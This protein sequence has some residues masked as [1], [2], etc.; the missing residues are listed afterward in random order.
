[1]R[2]FWQKII[3]VLKKLACDRLTEDVDFGK[4]KIIFSSDLGGYIKKRNCR[5]CGTENPHAYIEKPTHLKRVTVW[6]GFWSR[7]IIGTFFFGNE[8]EEAVTVNGDR[9]RPMLNECLFT[10]I[11]EEDFGNIW[12]QQDGSTCHTAEAILDV[13]RAVFVDRIISRRA[14]GVWP[15]RSWDLTPVDYYLWGAVKDK[16]YADKLETIDCWMNFCS[17]KLK[18]R[19]F[20][21]FGFNRTAL[22]ATQPKLYLM[23]CAQFLK[24]GLSAAKLMAFGHLGVEIW[25]RWTI[26]CEVPSKTSVTPTSSRDNWRFKGQYSW[27][28][29]WNTAAYNW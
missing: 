14:N 15:P 24:I 17:Q 10:K 29:W 5:I 20:A 4:K 12:F 1:M 11:E 7:C 28:Y 26:I 18:R 9:Y 22:R 13:L 6:C 19:L 16:R 23:F 3:V 25:H 8:Q 2:W 21:T 27:S